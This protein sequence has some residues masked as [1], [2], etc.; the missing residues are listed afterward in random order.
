MKHPKKEIRI[1]GIDD[2]PFDKNKDK[3]CLIVATVFRGG[4][5]LDG[6]LSCKVKVDGDD[7]TK[8]I[9]KLISKSKH[10]QQLKVIMLDGISVAGFN[11][12][13]I[14]ELNKKTR[15]P[16]IVLIRHMPNMKDIKKALKKFKDFKKRLTLLEKA[17]EIYKTNI[18]NKALYFQ[19]AG[20][21]N[22]QA[23]RIIRLSATRSLLPEPI[24]VSHLIASGIKKGESR[25]R[26]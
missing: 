9:I 10:K 8:K 1:L 24:R 5:F 25:G 19:I 26:A 15:L 14:Q 11:I 16:I 3:N 2:A 18:K 23:K 20:I 7:A 17:G 22:E 21:S 12:I 6:L 4:S 13:D